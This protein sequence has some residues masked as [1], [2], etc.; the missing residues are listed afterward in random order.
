MHDFTLE[1]VTHNKYTYHVASLF[2]MTVV[3][4]GTLTNPTNGQ[5][6][7]T[8]RTTFGQTATYSCDTGYILV[9]GNTRMCQATGIWSGSEPTCQSMLYQI[10][11]LSAMWWICLYKKINK[12]WII[13]AHF[14]TLKLVRYIQSCK[15]T[16]I[17][18]WDLLDSQKACTDLKTCHNQV[19]LLTKVHK[20]IYIVEKIYS[21]PREKERHISFLI[22]E[23][24][25]YEAKIE[26]SEKTGSHW[27][28]NPGHF[29]HLATTPGQPPAPTI[30]YMYCISGTECL[31]LTPGSHSVCAIR[32]LLEVDWKILFIY[33]TSYHLW[34]K[35][36]WAF[37]VSKPFSTWV[38]SW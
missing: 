31:S 20:D 23:F 4:C 34:G 17:T 8:G 2:F 30:L 11:N 14:R 27:E 7:H 19:K 13:F 1:I 15:H 18:A 32:I 6:S 5:V 9:G 37:T 28:S 38:L 26:E 35:M 10:L 33:F 36:L 12:K 22:N 29:C 21:Y 24:R 16:H 25:C 3:D